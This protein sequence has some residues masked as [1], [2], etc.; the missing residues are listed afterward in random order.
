MA[1]RTLLSRIGPRIRRHADAAGFV[2][3]R[4]TTSLALWGQPFSP[5]ETYR[6]HWTVAA[7]MIGGTLAELVRD[8]PQGT[9]D[10]MKG[11]PDA[12]P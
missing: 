9:Q 5:A 3:I 1:K 6:V 10:A 4:P 12:L 7:M 8:R 11:N 2:W